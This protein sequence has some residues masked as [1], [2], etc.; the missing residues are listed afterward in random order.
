MKSELNHTVLPNTKWYAIRVTYSREK[1][2]KEYFDAHAIE[3]FLPMYYKLVK[4]KGRM[5]K[6]LVPVVHNLIFVKSIRSRLDE[7]KKEVETVTP[8][9]YMIDL[10]TRKPIIVPESQMRSFIAVAGTLEEQLLYLDDQINN[11]L[12]K[13]CRVLVTGGIFSGV[14]GVVLRI[15]RDHRVVVSIKGVIAVATTFIPPSL[16]QRI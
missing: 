10:S 8:M 4:K 9:R 2:L 3:N 16:L 13:G 15:K 1:K 5:V 7:I 12:E 14:E 6:E 11:V